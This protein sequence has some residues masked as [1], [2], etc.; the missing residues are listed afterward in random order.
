MDNVNLC[1]NW[2][3]LKNNEIYL[4]F[5]TPLKE[6]NQAVKVIKCC[7]SVYV[8]LHREQPLLYPSDSFSRCCAVM[9]EG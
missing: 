1:V 7:L 3:F 8:T 5:K 6:L 2:V 9:D 4:L